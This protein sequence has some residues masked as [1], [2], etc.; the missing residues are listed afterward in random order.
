MAASEDSLHTIELGMQTVL[1]KAASVSE[2][3]SKLQSPYNPCPN[4][5]S[6][7]HLDIES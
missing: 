6:K 1:N 2:K 3:I 7:K 4:E 5:A